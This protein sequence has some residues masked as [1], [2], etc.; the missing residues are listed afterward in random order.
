MEQ[1]KKKD[2]L[3]IGALVSG[4]LTWYCYG[5]IMMILFHPW[6]LFSAKN[7]IGISISALKTPYAFLKGVSISGIVYY[8]I[9]ALRR[10]RR[11]MGYFILGGFCLWQAAETYFLSITGLIS[12]NLS[13]LN[14]A[15]LG[16]IGVSLLL[17]GLRKRT[18]ESGNEEQ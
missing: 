18:E 8:G 9:G 1:G 11:S 12:R 15:I 4:F 10:E 6:D 14:M 7:L 13:Y 16:V 2:R 3:L 17:T 5:L